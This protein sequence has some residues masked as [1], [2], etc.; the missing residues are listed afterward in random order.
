M[1]RCPSQSLHNILPKGI[2]ILIETVNVFT[3]TNSVHHFDGSRQWSQHVLPQISEQDIPSV[4]YVR[5]SVTDPR[6]VYRNKVMS[7]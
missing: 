7:T 1:D 3:V 5:K 4:S 6:D 2:N